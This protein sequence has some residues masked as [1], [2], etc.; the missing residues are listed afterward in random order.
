MEKERDP[1]QWWDKSWSVVTGCTPAGAG[2]DHCWARSLVTRFPVA[3]NGANF[4]NVRC[5]P[6]RLDEPLRR[7]KPTVYAVS[8]LGD[9]FHRDMPRGFLVHVFNAMLDGK[10]LKHRFVLLTKRPALAADFIARPPYNL[11]NRILLLASCWDQPSTDAACAALSA[12]PGLRWGMHLEPLLA[13]VDLE[14]PFGW[15]EENANATRPVWVVVGGEN[16]PGARPMDPQWA[17]S[18][19]DQC[20]AAGVPFWFKGWGTSRL[21][22]AAARD[23]RLRLEADTSREVPW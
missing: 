6:E 23:D 13:A 18:L 17:V 16:G 9:L 19:R 11:G 7:R 20:R 5:W 3:H 12:V 10:S 14:M 22:A 4:G 2:C 15:P 1:G 21:N 8:L